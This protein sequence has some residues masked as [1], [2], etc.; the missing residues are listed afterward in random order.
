[1]RSPYRVHRPAWKVRDATRLRTRLRRSPVRGWLP[2]TA[3]SARKTMS[4][5][6]L[7]VTLCTYNECE[8]LPALIPE[9]RKHAPDCDI[10][11]I[12]DSSPDGT[13][14][15]ADDFAARDP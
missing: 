6:R 15:I 8:N 7:L 1:M 3:H 4:A 10:L 9:I 14:A 13:G 2:S 12:D 5:E 11:V